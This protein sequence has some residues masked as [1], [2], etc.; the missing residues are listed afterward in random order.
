MC[1]I[2]SRVKGLYL[3]IGLI[4]LA[5]VPSAHA[6]SNSIGILPAYPDP[7]NARSNSIFLHTLKPGE[8]VKDGVRVIND[9]KDKRTVNLGVVDAITSTNG[10]FSCRQNSEKRKGMSNWVK[11]DKDQVTLEPGESEVVDFTITSP[12]DASPGE[13]GSCIT[14][15]DT[16]SYGEKKA[17]TGGVSLGMRY[18]I[19]MAVTTPGKIVKKLT[20]TRVDILRKDDGN[21]TV[22]T[23]SRNDGN[24]SLDVQAR[25]Q[26]VSALGQKTAVKDDGKYPVMPGA[27]TG[28]PYEF[29][30]PFWGGV[31]MARTSLAY[32]ANPLD[33]LGENVGAVK[34]VRGES[35]Y[36]VMIP[37]PKAIAVYAL[38]LLTLIG[39][40]FWWLWRRRRIRRLKTRGEDYVVRAGETLAIIAEKHGTTW[41][42][43]AR[44]NN[45]KAPY[46]VAV[47]QH[48]IVI[49]KNKKQNQSGWSLPA[50]PINDSQE[51]PLSN[52]QMPVDM[53]DDYRYGEAYPVTP[54]ASTSRGLPKRQS[55]IYAPKPSSKH[56]ATRNTGSYGWAKPSSDWAPRVVSEDELERIIQSKTKRK[57]PRTPNSKKSK[58][59]SVDNSG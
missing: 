37:H 23:L 48:L 34:T 21:Y 57:K 55:I 43:L 38:L 31:Y 15:Q 12:K 9:T 51:S 40:P 45:L 2:N 5:I 36:F 26:L 27:T 16:L 17:K 39:S 56:H 20:V 47:G 44:I 14:G 24:V 7:K 1:R 52:E 4:V 59:R 35:G 25:A 13:H 32:N 46:A 11:L 53:P 29:K 3:I 33:G 58:P 49:R 19:R 54:P 8:S 6:E 10:S 22:N 30:R 42:K 50:M 18:A 41:K 28:W